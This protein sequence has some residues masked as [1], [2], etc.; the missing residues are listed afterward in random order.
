[1]KTRTLL[2]VVNLIAAGIFGLIVFREMAK[3]AKRW[4]EQW[5][6]SRKAE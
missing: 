1:M 3:S 6:D 5:E 4:R 2:W